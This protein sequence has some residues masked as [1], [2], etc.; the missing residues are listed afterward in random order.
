[1]S[2][3]D[4][5]NAG[6]EAAT[7]ATAYSANRKLNSMQSAA[8]Y[9]QAR[10]MLIEAMRAFLFKISRDI[11]NTEELID[12]FPKQGY[13]VSKVL[14][15]RLTASGLTSDLFPDISDKE[16]YYETQK[17]LERVIKNSEGKLT[18]NEVSQA[19]QAI[20]YIN[21]YDLLVKAVSST[22]AIENLQATQENW[23]KLSKGNS[24]RKISLWL[25]IALLVSTICLIALIPILIAF[26]SVGVFGYG[27]E[28][29]GVYILAIAAF[30]AC[31]ILLVGSIVAIVYGAMTSSEFRQLQ[32]QRTI[33]QSAVLP[34]DERQ[35]ASS[36]FG[37]LNSIQLQ[38]LL[39]KRVAFLTPII[40]KD[41]ERMLL[42]SKE[43][44]S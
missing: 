30:L 42:P 15:G 33:W 25:G 26:I 39:N 6:L 40:G 22:S 8:Q 23:N 27:A 38:E 35:T 21:E 7:L 5:L 11:K 19:D 36:K 3:W 29:A 14:H 18:S 9:E 20:K 44:D 2:G 1:M 41:F 24:K 16:Y 10:R 12:Q 31:G 28:D 13:I 34:Q 32:G 17:R 4:L 37:E 43:A